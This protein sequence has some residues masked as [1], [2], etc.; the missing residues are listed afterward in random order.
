MIFML[1]V[2]LMK[3]TEYF[4]KH[5]HLAK[6][7]CLQIIPVLLNFYVVSSTSTCMY[8]F[9]KTIF[10]HKMYTETHIHFYCDL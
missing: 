7:I 4:L 8:F 10:P 3:K 2:T 6:L 9:S 5:C 1:F